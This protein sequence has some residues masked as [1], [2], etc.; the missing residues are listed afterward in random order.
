M[1][2][3]VNTQA[4]DRRVSEGEWAGAP[5]RSPSAGSEMGLRLDTKP[6]FL[7]RAVPEAGENRRKNGMTPN[8]R[9]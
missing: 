6:R 8:G 5:D 9:A 3:P 7:A 4:C 2:P 1:T